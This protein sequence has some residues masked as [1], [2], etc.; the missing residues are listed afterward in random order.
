VKNARTRFDWLTRD[1]AV[2][3]A[4]CADPKCN[5]LCTYGFY[6]DLL[7][8]L[9]KVYGDDFLATV[10]SK[11]PIFLF[12][13]SEDPVIGNKEGLE[14]IAQL[15]RRFGIIDL[16]TKCYNGDRHESFNELNKQEVIEDIVNWFTRHIR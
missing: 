11:L 5:F 13:G 15:L 4:Y 8:G 3:D 14:K 2:V 6:R 1:S 12:C 16:E 7:H 10:P 9:K